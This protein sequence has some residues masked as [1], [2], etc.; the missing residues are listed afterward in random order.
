MAP[1]EA[2][3]AHPDPQREDSLQEAIGLGVVPALAREGG[4]IY[5]YSV[6]MLSVLGAH[7]VLGPGDGGRRVIFTS[8]TGH[9][10][11]RRLARAGW[12]VAPPSRAR[13]RDIAQ[14]SVAALLGDAR[15]MRVWAHVRGLRRNAAPS[16]LD[17]IAHRPDVGAWYRQCGADLMLFTAPNALAFEAG[18]PSIVPIH[19]LQHRL[20]PHF[21]EVAV[22]GEWERREY[23]YRNAARHAALVLADSEVGKQ[24]ILD[25]YGAYGARPERIWVLPFMPAAYLPEHVD[26]AE[27]DRVVRA[28]SLP[29]RY[30][31]YPAQFWPHKNHVRVIEALAVL[32]EDYGLMPTVVFCGSNSGG[33]RRR[34]FD[35]VVRSA[36]AKGVGGQVQ[37]IG[38]VPD[39]DMGALYAQATALVMPTYFGPT[40]I[41]VLEAWAYGCPVITS[42]LRGIREQVAEAGLLVDPNSA[43]AL[44]DAVRRVWTE[45]ETARTLVKRG[46]A[47][48]KHYSPSEFQRRLEGAIAQARAI[49]SSVS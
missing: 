18:V 15:A 28:Y 7:H 40:N 42:D 34:T 46:F 49:T 20:Q 26:S 31:F 11:V 4:G 8:H 44:A 3:G 27:V 29:K 13:G 32:R 30:L 39:R 47:R 41:P 6:T 45:P 17:R 12:T 36:Q 22:D 21:E 23:L 24:D 1:T 37:T 25:I 2:P 5:Q 14:R 33:L 35:A 9:E 38:F 48:L 16:D 10:Q 43:Q 19:D